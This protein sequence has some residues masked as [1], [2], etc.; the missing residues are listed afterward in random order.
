MCISSTLHYN[1]VAAL[2]GKHSEVAIKPTYD[3]DK[4][5]SM[6]CYFNKGE[7][8]GLRAITKKHVLT[9]PYLLLNKKNMDPGAN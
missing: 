8:L 5:H 6:Y 3:Y 2:T 7:W 1:R 4:A 9:M